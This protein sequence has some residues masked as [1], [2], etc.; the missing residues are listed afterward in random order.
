MLMDREDE[1]DRPVLKGAVL[2]TCAIAAMSGPRRLLGKG[3]RT[4]GGRQR[5]VRG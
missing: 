1:G 3:N 5:L 2:V 4:Q